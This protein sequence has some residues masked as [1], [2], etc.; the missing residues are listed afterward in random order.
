MTEKR[1][2]YQL[3]RD[4]A[5]EYFLKF[6]QRQFIR[7]WNLPHDDQSVGLRFLG[8]DYRLFRDSGKI[9]RCWDG[10]EAEHSE[11]LSI[12]DLLCHEGQE[13]WAAGR[14]APVNSLKGGSPL[15]VGTDFHTGIAKKF[16]ANPEK[17]RRAC[18]ALGGTPVEMGDM[19][20]RFP[21]FGQLQ[22]ILKFYRADEDFPAS[23]VL[24]WD[25]NLLQ[26][27][28][29]ETVFYIAGVLLRNIET[30]FGK[31]EML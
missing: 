9:L 20:F 18:L 16:D 29:Y 31:V 10:S 22:M 1:D 28:F 25:E 30:E 14:Y 11:V 26:F 17:F 2:N 13:K 4:R 5:K 6:D 3:S 24:L 12:F 19:G 8:R 23:L 21:L 7:F 15:G 27:V